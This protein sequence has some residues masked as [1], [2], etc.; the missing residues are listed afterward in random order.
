M[1]V[2]HAAL[3]LQIEPGL[4]GWK[5]SWKMYVLSLTFL[6]YELRDLTFGCGRSIY[7][8]FLYEEFHTLHGS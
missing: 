3:V 8:A 6:A 5:V 4:G 7:C 2:K 1:W